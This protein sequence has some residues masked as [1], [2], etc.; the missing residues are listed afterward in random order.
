LTPYELEAIR[1][2]QFKMNAKAPNRQA[3]KK[4]EDVGCGFTRM[5]PMKTPTSASIRVIR[6]N[7]WLRSLPSVLGALATW[8]S[9]QAHLKKQTQCFA[10][11]LSRPML[12]ESIVRPIHCRIV[13]AGLPVLTRVDG[14]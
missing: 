12:S 5:T 9:S 14:S 4:R 10:Q 2:K 8:R 1:E 7:L 13:D 6:E 11:V 3:K